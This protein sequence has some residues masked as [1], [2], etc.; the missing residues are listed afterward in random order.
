MTAPP[1]TRTLRRHRPFVLL[2]A[3]QTAGSVGRQITALALALES[4]HQVPIELGCLVG[5]Q[6]SDGRV[7]LTRDLH[8]L[9]DELRQTCLELRDERQRLLELEADPGLP[10]ECPLACPFLAT[11]RP[12]AADQPAA[13]LV[14]A[15]NGHA[16]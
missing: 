9:D 7:Q 2:C 1:E 3:E 14:P 5:V 4:L 11:C 12:A 10:A 16:R 15:R 6:V 13:G 8:P